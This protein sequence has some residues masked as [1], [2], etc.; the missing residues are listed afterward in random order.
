MKREV[1]RIGLVALVWAAGISAAGA[2]Q[3]NPA[4]VKIVATKVTD[5]FYTIDGQGGRM[6]VQVGPDGVF[7]VDSQFAPLTERLA[8]EIKKVRRAASIPRQH[9]R[10]RGSH[11][12]QRELRQA[13]VSSCPGRCSVSV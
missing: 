3:Q 9:A 7:I 1:M 13:G 6:G 2:Q 5:S 12:R 10:A 8:A 11:R 4:E